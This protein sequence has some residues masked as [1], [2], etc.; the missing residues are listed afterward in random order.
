MDSTTVQYTLHS[1]H[2][3]CAAQRSHPGKHVQ[4]TGVLGKYTLQL[5][6]NALACINNAMPTLLEN[7]T[8]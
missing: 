3:N 4:N 6:Q 7:T 1:Q 8:L 5:E 2:H